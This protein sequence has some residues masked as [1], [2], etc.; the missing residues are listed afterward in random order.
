[1]RNI[2]SLFTFLLALNVSAQSVGNTDYEMK[3]YDWE[4]SPVLSKIT[5]EESK[6]NIVFIKDF[7]VTEYMYVG[8]TFCEFNTVHKKIK[9][10]T[11]AGVEISNKVYISTYYGE[12][13]LD[14]K[15][16]SISK[17]GKITVFD[18]S[19]IKH[20]DNYENAGPFTIFALE[21][22]EVGSEVEYVYTTKVAMTDLNYDS[23][24]FQR[25]YPVKNMSFE[26]YYPKHL[27]FI[28]KSYNGLATAVTDTTD[29][30]KMKMWVKSDY[31]KAAPDEKYSPE[32]AALQRLEFKF[33]KNK[34]TGR[35]A[36]TS[37][38]DAAKY[39]YRRAYE[40]GDPKKY[41]AEMKAVTKM[42]K[43]LALDN[44]DEEDKIRKIEEHI[45]SFLLNPES[46]YYLVNDI[47]KNKEATAFGL[48]RTFAFALTAAGIDHQ[49]VLTSNKYEL[50]FDGEFQSWH[51]LQKF[52]MYFPKYNKF[53]APGEMYMR[54]GLVPS[55][56]VYTNG[57]FIKV[58]SLGD[59]K[60]A[61]ARIAYI[62]G[63][64]ETSNYDDLDVTVNFGSDFST[65]EM[66][67]VHSQGGYFAPGYHLWVKNYKQEQK[68]EFAD[69]LLK[70]ATD[71]S[72]VKEYTFGPDKGGDILKNPFIAS[73]KVQ[74]NS[75][76]EKA[77]NKY[78]FNI[79]SVIGKQVEMYQEKAR[80]TDI[81]LSYPHA[82]NRVIK[83]TVPEGYTVKNINDLN[84]D[85]YMEENGKRI[86]AFEVTYVQE[87]NTYTVTIHEYYKKLS[88]PKSDID[89]FKKVI[90]AAA[91]FNKQ[92]LIIEKK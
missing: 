68:D 10:N 45:K 39:Y 63:P 57:L 90:N 5:E 41:K 83:F 35:D 48:V 22:V 42:L 53:L 19:N 12:Q 52:L 28:S 54:Y 74:A 2:L 81:L 26:F 72:E 56:Y 66:D 32:D 86:L 61:V 82:Y 21:G 24:I 60:N 11:D 76:V 30:G 47:V 43:G 3:N 25:N 49:M 13:V 91:D 71:D 64:D 34:S 23:R 92:Q 6:F 7:L 87:G 17:D 16:R 50:P 44:L 51:Y 1:M 65:C 38:D 84:M 58:I 33:S 27:E 89:P 75:L 69:D 40:H 46:R 15:A 14:L 79:G 70:F 31:I 77:G 73:G 88:M 20:V 4:A 80:E 62:D 85:V 8:D 59:L 9:L 18:R 78:I 37:W 55:G 67:I 36:G 29:N